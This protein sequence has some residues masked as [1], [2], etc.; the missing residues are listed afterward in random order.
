[1]TIDELER[2]HTTHL[3]R[4]P[5]HADALRPDR[6]ATD[7]M[8]AAVERA[9]GARLPASYRELLRRFGGGDFIFVSLMSADPD[10]DNYLPRCHA[11]WRESLDDEYVPF[12]D[13]GC[14]GVYAFRRDGAAVGERVYYWNT[15]A[16]VQETAW[17]NAL[18]F[19][20]DNAYG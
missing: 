16:G 19:I 1:M 6:R 9:L 7:E 8:L 3:A 18:S 20:A 4:Y 12:C 17:A 13:D 10:S 2:V 15:D 11:T 5:R 14:G